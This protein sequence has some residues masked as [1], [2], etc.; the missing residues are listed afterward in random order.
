MK[1]LTTIILTI[2]LLATAMPALADDTSRAGDIVAFGDCLSALD[3]SRAQVG[4]YTNRTAQWSR[5]SF[6]NAPSPGEY[7][8]FASLQVRNIWLGYGNVSERGYESI[9]WPRGR[10]LP[11]YEWLNLSSFSTGEAITIRVVWSEQTPNEYYILPM[12]NDN[13]GGGGC[14]FYSVGINDFWNVMAGFNPA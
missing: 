6:S 1:H 4:Y 12:K 2:V 13:H 10:T 5:Q 3:V 11:V 14:Q 8:A 9:D 7:E